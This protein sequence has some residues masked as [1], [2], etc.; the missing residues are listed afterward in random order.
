MLLFP[1]LP[2]TSS[3]SP[4]NTCTL[5]CFTSFTSDRPEGLPLGGM[6]QERWQALY[7]QYRWSPQFE[8]AT[9]RASLD[10][11]KNVVGME[12]ALK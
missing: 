7:D 6:S 11:L 1:L 8:R 5:P 9:R 4:F 2:N 10:E 3:K 12:Q